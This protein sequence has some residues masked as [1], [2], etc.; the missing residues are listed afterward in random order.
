VGIG[1]KAPDFCLKTETGEDWFLS[2]HEGNVVALLFYPQDETMVC[3]RQLCSVRDHWQAYLKTKA[4]IIG[5]SPGTS[6]QHK[7]FSDKYKLP[8]TLLA[9]A[10]RS[11]TETYSFHWFFP[12]SFTRGIVVIDAKGF[13]RSRKVMLRAFRPSDGSVIASIYRARTDLLEEK[14]QSLRK[15]IKAD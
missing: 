5:V 8:I 7:K 15:N 13:I 4:Q 14:Y 3:T 12:T 9:D 1:E 6:S 2:A 11:V 10:D